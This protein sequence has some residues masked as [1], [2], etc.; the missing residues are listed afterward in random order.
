MNA[1][2]DW[3][4]YIYIYMYTYIYIYV[5]MWYIPNIRIQH[6]Y[7]YIHIYSTRESI[8][9]DYPLYHIGI[10]MCVLLNRFHWNCNVAYCLVVFQAKMRLLDPSASPIQ[11]KGIDQQCISLKYAKMVYPKNIIRTILR[12]MIMKAMWSSL[13]HLICSDS[14]YKWSSLLGAFAM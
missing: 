5:Y 11:K 14:E 3:Y 10:L 6:K 13:D 1:W 7:I 4:T 9:Y 2:S 12:Y 8:W